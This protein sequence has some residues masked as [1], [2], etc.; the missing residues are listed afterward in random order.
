[1]F[2]DGGVAGQRM[3]L[4]LMESRIKDYETILERSDHHP[5]VPERLEN[6]L[7]SKAELEATMTTQ[8]Q[9]RA[10]MVVECHEVDNATNLAENAAWHFDRSE[11][12]DNDT[13]WVWDLAAEFVPADY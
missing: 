9:V 2:K 13:H 10:Y 12:L 11:W 4:A 3:I 6:L 7:N 1:M 8:A 5:D